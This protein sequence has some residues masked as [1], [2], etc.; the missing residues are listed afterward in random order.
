MYRDVATWIDTLNE[1]LNY[2]AVA[3][4]PGHTRVLW[5]NEIKDVYKR[6]I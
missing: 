5:Q 2:P 4:L 6:Q 1:I 3:L